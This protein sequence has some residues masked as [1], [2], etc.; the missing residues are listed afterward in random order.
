MNTEAVLKSKEFLACDKNVLSH[1]LKMDAL[2]SG[3][4]EVF[5]ACMLW[6]KSKSKCDELTFEIVQQYLG[7]LYYEICVASLEMN[8]L[9]LLEQQFPKVVER[10]YITVGFIIA[11]PEC[12]LVTKFKKRQRKAVSAV[13]ANHMDEQ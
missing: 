3:E 6:V 2:S 12:E 4:Y 10:D 8:E 7:D 5:K 13:F 11:L 9:L 1:I